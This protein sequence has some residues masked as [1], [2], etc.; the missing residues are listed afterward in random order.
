MATQLSL[1]S[2]VVGIALLLAGIG[3][4]VL[5]ASGVLREQK[6]SA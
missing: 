1:F 4:I 6:T 5:A 3:F 2:F